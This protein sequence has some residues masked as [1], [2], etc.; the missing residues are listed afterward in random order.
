[1]VETA[2]T[3]QLIKEELQYAMQVIC[4]SYFLKILSI[5]IYSLHASIVYVL[6]MLLRKLHNK[7]KC[8]LARWEVFLKYKIILILICRL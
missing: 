6:Q 2:C 7:T 5:R 3:T 8:L 1:M 4:S